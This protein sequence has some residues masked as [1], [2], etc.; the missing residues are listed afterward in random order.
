MWLRIK[1]NND[2][3]SAV[4]ME[5]QPG[6]ARPSQFTG[7]HILFIAHWSAAAAQI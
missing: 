2:V 4:L 3:L 1:G 5:S 6:W 7:I